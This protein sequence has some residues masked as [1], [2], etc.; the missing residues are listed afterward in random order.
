MKILKWLG[1][2]AAIPV[3]ALVAFS[4]IARLGDGP[5][6][7]FPGGPLIGGVAHEGPEP[8]WSFAKDYAELEF[9]LVDPPV[10]RIIWLQVVDGKL[11]GV[12]GYMNSTFGKLWKQWPL[13]AEEDPRAVIRVD[14][15]RYDRKLVR[16]APDDPVLPAIAAEMKRKY[17]APLT[18]EMAATGDAWFYAFEPR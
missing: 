14:G 8:D 12:S 5:T 7:I 18:A 1:I 13:Q 2:L 15:V 9:Q 4:G 16:L 3:I 10:S 11:Y 17:D 6:A